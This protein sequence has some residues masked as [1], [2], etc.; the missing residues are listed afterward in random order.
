M[1]PRQAEGSGT[2][3]SG[4]ERGGGSSSLSDAEVGARLALYLEAIRAW[5]RAVD[6][7]GNV[8]VDK[9]LE[10]LVTESLAALPWIPRE[11]RLLDVGS[12]NGIPA[13]PLLLAR[14]DLQGVLLEPRER[15]W[16][17]L[18]ATARELGCR[19]EILRERLVEH[20]ARGYDVITVRGLAIEEWW[21]D[22]CARLGPDGT[23]LWW[24]GRGRGP[25][26]AEDV[27]MGSV[28][29]CELLG[30][31]GSVLAVMRPRST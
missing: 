30:E 1:G 7:V 20:A 27:A 3:G 26:A 13:I 15:R 19:A 5:S 28:I 2:R 4:T 17:F 6:L 29:R 16:V 10:R 9:T 24:T 8:H 31:G 21:T 12:G 25:R 18:R 23:I 22:A 11:G 14:P